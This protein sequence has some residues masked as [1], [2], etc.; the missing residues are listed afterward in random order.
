MRFTLTEIVSSFIVKN[1]K[2]KTKQEYDES[3]KK[4]KP[5]M[6]IM[7]SGLPSMA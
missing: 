5:T 6:E 7:I 1:K 3:Q 4:N 2:Q